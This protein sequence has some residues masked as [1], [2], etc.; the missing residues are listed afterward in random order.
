MTATA[1]ASTGAVKLDTAALLDAYRA[2]ITPAAK[3]FV[4]GRMSA[5]EL[6][7]RWLPYFQGPFT[8]YE[9]AVQ[10][11][12]R[13]AYGPDHG[14]EPGPPHA[15]PAYAEQLKHFPVT[16]SHNNLERLV[17]VLAVELGDRTAS[18]TVTPE[19]VIDFAYVI[20]ALD[21]FMASLVLTS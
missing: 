5:N 1:E 15:D 10:A 17:D 2:Q 13:D 6:R 16:I 8:E 20:D 14:I 3:A 21:R 18:A 9:L 11:A 7:S 19:R 4:E 12:W